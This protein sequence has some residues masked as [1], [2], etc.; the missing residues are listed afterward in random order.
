MITTEALSRV[1]RPET[2]FVSIGWA[3]GEI[4]TVQPM[5]SLTRCIREYQREHASRIIIHS[6]AGQAPLYEKTTFRS[7]DV[8]LLSLDAGK[9]Y[10]P[11]G[12]G[13]LIVRGGTPLAP[14]FFGGKQER[15]LRPGT[16]NVALVVAFA[17][18]Y[19]KL[20]SE[21]ESESKRLRDIRDFFAHELMA[22]IPAIIR[23][24]ERDIQPHILNVSIPGAVNEYFVLSLDAAGFSLS[25]KSACREGEKAHSHVVCALGPVQQGDKEI[26]SAEERAT[27]TLRFSLGRETTREDMERCA[28]TCAEIYQRM[29]LQGDTEVVT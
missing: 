5:I 6:D 4:G 24:G 27:C 23:N 11:R 10:G 19:E 25:A 26:L 3:N 20:V 16:E 7:L 13:A 8:D 22:R 1:V 14:I 12:V 21:R 29:R 28:T 15:G 18:A 9:L 17:V 2:V